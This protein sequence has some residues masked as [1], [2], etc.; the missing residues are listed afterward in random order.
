ML[1]S[2]VIL[3][4]LDHGAAV[5]PK[6][7]RGM[8]A[9]LEA[10]DHGHFEAMRLL[11]NRGSDPHAVNNHGDGAADLSKWG[12]DAQMI[13]E[14]LSNLGVVRDSAL[15]T[16]PDSESR[17]VMFNNNLMIQTSNRRSNSIRN[18]KNILVIFIHNLRHMPN[19][20]RNST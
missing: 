12:R 6:N 10:A 5:T 16:T 8:T 15:L 14:W 2:Q 3:E 13:S 17:R 19:M 11:H 20:R 7:E 9:F 1:T 18:H 4:L